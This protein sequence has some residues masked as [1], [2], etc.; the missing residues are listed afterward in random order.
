MTLADDKGR[1]AVRATPN[2]GSDAVVLPKPGEASVLLVRV[3]ATPE[4][5]RANEAI[6]ALLAKVLGRPRSELSLL[7]GATSRDKLILISPE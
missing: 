2:A 6:L 5:G 1:V 7:R 4:D 3:T